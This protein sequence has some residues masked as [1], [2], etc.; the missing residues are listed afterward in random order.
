VSETNLDHDVADAIRIMREGL[1]TKTGQLSIPAAAIQSLERVAREAV[2]RRAFMALHLAEM[3]VRVQ[4]AEA[5]VERARYLA[6]ESEK[7]AEHFLQQ[8][9]IAEELAAMGMQSNMELQTEKGAPVEILSL[10]VKKNEDGSD[11]RLLVTVRM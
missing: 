8:K 11:K 9:V 7:R 6:D 2:N 1:D 10:D 5:A 4:R 3:A